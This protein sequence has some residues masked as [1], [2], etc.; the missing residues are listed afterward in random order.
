MLPL[1]LKPG[2]YPFSFGRY[3]LLELLGKG[4]FARV[5]LAEMRGSAGFRKH[6]ALKIIHHTYEGDTADFIREGRLGGLLKH[7]NVVDTYDIGVEDGQAFIAM[8]AVDGASLAELYKL[9]ELPPSV[10]LE[11]GLSVCRALSY[12]HHLQGP[13]DTRGIIHRDLKPGNILIGWDGAIKV[14]DFG[15][16]VLTGKD[17]LAAHPSAG[18][19]PYMSPEQ[20]NDEPLDNRSDL[21]SLCIVLAEMSLGRRLH[22]GRGPEAM[23]QQA[24]AIEERLHTSDLLDEMNSRVPG[25]GPIVT[26]GLRIDPGERFGD[27][28][29]IAAELRDLSQRIN[30]D[31]SVETWLATFLNRR[32]LDWTDILSGSLPVPPD[33]TREDLAGDIKILAKEDHKN[34]DPDPLAPHLRELASSPDLDATLAAVA[35][36]EEAL[37]GTPHRHRVKQI[38]R[39][40]QELSQSGLSLVR[41]GSFPYLVTDRSTGRYWYQGAGP[42]EL[43]PNSISERL[44]YSIAAHGLEWSRIEL[45]EKVWDQ[46]YLPPSSD[47]SLRVM[48]HK[49]RKKL[50]DIG[51]QVERY[52]DGQYVLSSQPGVVE[53]RPE[54]TPRIDGE[55]TSQREVRVRKSTNLNRSPNLFFGRDEDLARLGQLHAS[56][57]GLVTVLGP[58]G[59]GKTRLAREWALAELKTG[60]V[61]NAWFCD[62][63]VA[64]TPLGVLGVVA[65]ALEVPLTSA[66]QGIPGIIEKLGHAIAAHDNTLLILDNAEHVAQATRE[67]LTQWWG[68]AENARFLVTSR[69]PLGLEMEQRLLLAPL[70]LPQSTG[71]PATNAAVTLFVDRAQAVDPGFT[72]SDDNSDDVAAIVAELDGLPLAIELAAARAALWSAKTLRSRLSDRFKLLSRGSSSDSA[73]QVTLQGA[74]DWSWD[75]L[76]PWEQSA[77]AQCS[78][79]RGG[80]DWTAAEQVIDTS[81]HPE[82]PWVID[83]LA[84]LVEHSLLMPEPS[85]GGETRLTLLVSV[86]AHAAEKLSGLGEEARQAVERRHAEY[87]AALGEDGYLDS[88]DRHGGVERRAQ[89]QRELENLMIA[90]H[91]ASTA[92]WPEHAAK[93]C[94]AV[95]AIQTINGPYSK[96]LELTAQVLK[97]EI[98]P[99]SRT[100]LLL[101]TSRLI[102]YTQ[103]ADQ[104]LA[105]VEEALEISQRVGDRKGESRALENLSFVMRILSH[106]EEAIAA[107]ERGLVID[108]DLGDRRHEGRMLG[109]L[110]LLY[111]ERGEIP[112]AIELLEAAVALARSEDDLAEIGLALGNLGLIYREQ[113]RMREAREHL[114]A[115]LAAVR[116]HGSRRYEGLWMGALGNLEKE[117]GRLS[118]AMEMYD[119]ALSVARDLG[120]RRY[121][122]T[123]IAQRGLVYKQQG[124]FPEAIEQLLAA[125]AIEQEMGHRTGLAINLCN[126]G[127]IMI[128]QGDWASAEKHFEKAIE[129]G[130]ETRPHIAGAGRGLLA[131]VRAHHGDLEGARSLLARGEQ[132]LRGI[133]AA[134][135]FKLLYG[136]V[137]IEHAAGDR[138]TAQT[139]FKE[140][141]AIAKQLGV[142][143][144]SEFGRMV[145]ELSELLEIPTD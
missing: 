47:A 123:W 29:E 109:S 124:R 103:S 61:D 58:P 14:A 33:K 99:I 82:A 17:G 46:P 55:R 119:S 139:V 75:L 2:D 143:P 23:R 86:A 21:F 128:L 67:A 114:E 111:K 133:R 80:F 40:N 73:R 8:E 69:I 11:V 130:E 65:G 43:R 144:D 84:A 53:W 22:K 93:A 91:R 137:R 96:A 60:A 72:L 48:A 57:H 107:I 20:W 4:G 106:R 120:D 110:G 122:S 115:G 78:V 25:I 28:K 121:E 39:I 100:R 105:T 41:P 12:A 31:P 51:M 59:T 92:P 88:L 83:T 134:S 36:L 138:D 64:H 102:R 35:R 131:R 117:Q 113:A 19:P 62:L 77:L 132:Q 68:M 76:K 70:P 13:G 37:K 44:L 94:R 45:Y 66:D 3:T 9:S 18:S 104:A 52:G 63:S 1:H 108:R 79:F 112:K 6:I 7:R 145:S 116:A 56:S 32:E 24:M 97:L 87:Y 27:A 127:E 50:K 90:T 85:P 126:L 42:V 54:T 74:L 30:P 16:A 10:V 140:V 136:R 142:P 38:E 71:S 135:L 95:V 118:A 101:A 49:I 26:H 98:S 89:M 5:F 125:Q 81:E 34:L 141:V 129:I 15:I